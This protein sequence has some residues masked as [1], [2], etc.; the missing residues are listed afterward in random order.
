MDNISFLLNEIDNYQKSI[1]KEKMNL[2]IYQQKYNNKIAEKSECQKILKLCLGDIKD[3]LNK[4][5]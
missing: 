3:K 1:K 5:V 2:N 4:E